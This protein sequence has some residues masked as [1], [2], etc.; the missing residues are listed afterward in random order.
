MKHEKEF[1]AQYT[2]Q[3]RV[4]SSSTPKSKGGEYMKFKILEEPE[5]V[6]LGYVAYKHPPRS[7]AKYIKRHAK[8]NFSELRVLSAGDAK[9]FKKL[10]R[11]ERPN[12][13]F[14]IRSESP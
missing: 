9:T 3:S 11:R 10:V 13:H 12:T 2:I 4:R 7:Y 14:R 8:T 6:R 1:N 5:T